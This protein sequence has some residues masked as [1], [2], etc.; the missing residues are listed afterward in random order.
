LGL[1]DC[2]WD[3]SLH[4]KYSEKKEEKRKREEKV[5]WKEWFFLRVFQGA[6]PEE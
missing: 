4:G 1:L 2:A 6:V 3:N 5:K